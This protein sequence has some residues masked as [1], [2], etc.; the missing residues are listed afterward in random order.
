M[1]CKPFYMTVNTFLCGSYLHFCQPSFLPYAFRL[2]DPGRLTRQSKGSS[3]VSTCVNPVCSS[4]GASGGVSGSLIRGDKNSTS[5]A[6]TS[7]RAPCLPSFSHVFSAT[8][9]ITHTFRPFE[10]N[11]AHISP[12]S[13]HATTS[14][15]SASRLP[16]AFACFRFTATVNEQTFTPLVV[17]LNS[18]SLVR[19]PIIVNLLISHSPLI[20]LTSIVHIFFGL[21]I[22]V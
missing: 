21:E 2:F 11:L 15:K 1:F 17:V 12:R 13:R 6:V 20:F 16:S 18:G 3:S 10:R 22:Y 14:K 19:L 9:P 8:A 4:F 7:I 5:S